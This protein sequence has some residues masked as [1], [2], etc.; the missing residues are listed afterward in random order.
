MSFLWFNR[1]IKWNKWPIEAHTSR[2]S[3]RWQIDPLS[4]FLGEESHLP[5]PL[6]VMFHWRSDF[7]FLPQHKAV[8][9]S[10]A[11]N[12]SW[13]RI[14]FAT[15]FMSRR[16]TFLLFEKWFYCLRKWKKLSASDWKRLTTKTTIIIGTTKTYVG[17]K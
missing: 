12:R 16:I 9:K 2:A 14:P 13:N 1:A 15:V 8:E 5:W 4:D 3:K 10:F 17:F 7:I 11:S 6:L